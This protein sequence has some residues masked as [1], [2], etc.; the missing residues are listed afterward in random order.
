MV[1]LPQLHSEFTPTLRRTCPTVE[2]VRHKNSN[3]KKFRKKIVRHFF[4]DYNIGFCA[5][6]YA[7]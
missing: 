2:Q 7:L 4:N 5:Q 3:L 1:N 6:G